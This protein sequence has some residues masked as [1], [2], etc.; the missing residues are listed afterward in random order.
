MSGASA[1]LVISLCGL[2]AGAS[3]GFLTLWQLGPKSHCHK[4]IRWKCMAFLLSSL[5]GHMASLLL[6]SVG[7]GSR[8]RNINTYTGN[9]RYIE[10]TFVRATCEMGDFIVIIFGKYYLPQ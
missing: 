6:Y 1:E 7:A 10:V 2:S 4:R 5:T 3:V 9:R 8:G